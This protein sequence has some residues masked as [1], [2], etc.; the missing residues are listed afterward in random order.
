M[1]VGYKA[2]GNELVEFHVWH[3]GQGRDWHQILAHATP[4]Q[5]ECLGIPLPGH[6]Y[7]TE[8]TLRL[9]QARWPDWDMSEYF[10]RLKE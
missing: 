10:A 4:A 9:T 8:R 2:A 3:A 1:T 5:L 6:D 7:W